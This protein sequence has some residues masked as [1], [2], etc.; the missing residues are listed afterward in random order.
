[1][2]DFKPKKSNDFLSVKIS[3]KTLS[4]KCEYCEILKRNIYLN[5][6]VGTFQKHMRY[7]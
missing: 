2:T 7:M 6:D 5:N 1:M 4:K 3:A